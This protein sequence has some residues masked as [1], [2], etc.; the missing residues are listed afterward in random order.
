MAAVLA[1]T[2]SPCLESLH[3]VI[4]KNPIRPK[5]LTMSSKYPKHLKY[6]PGECQQATD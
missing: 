6:H 4:T 5:G 2:Q 3:D 1:Q